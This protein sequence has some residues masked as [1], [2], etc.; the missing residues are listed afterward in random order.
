MIDHF[1]NCRDLD[2]SLKIADL[3]DAMIDER[4]QRIL[5]ASHDTIFEHYFDVVW[6]IPFKA[7][8]T[9]RYDS[10]QYWRQDSR[11]S[12]WLMQWDGFLKFFASILNRLESLKDSAIWK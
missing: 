5:I 9:K 10:V 12:N 2:W 4:M 11:N 6:V 7:A 1:V 8:L 3:D